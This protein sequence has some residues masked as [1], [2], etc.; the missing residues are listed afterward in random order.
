MDSIYLAARAGNRA[1]AGYLVER[2]ETHGGWGFNFLHKQALLNNKEDFSDFRK[3]SV[4]KKP[5][6][7][8]K[9]TP[10]HMAA[11]NPNPKYDFQECCNAGDAN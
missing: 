4:T 2:Q 1:T 11:I 5:N 3:V 9:I 10:L 7:N 6:E 8:A